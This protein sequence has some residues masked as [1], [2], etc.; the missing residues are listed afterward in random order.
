MGVDYA[1]KTQSVASTGQI[2]G[3]NGNFFTDGVSGNIHANQGNFASYVQ[4]GAGG[5]GLIDAHGNLTIGGFTASGETVAGSLQT[6]T[7]NAQT[8]T[9]VANTLLRHITGASAFTGLILTAGTEA[10]QEVILVNDSANAQTFA[11]SGT[12]NVAEGTSAN[13]PA[14]G[15]LVLVW[16]ANLSLWV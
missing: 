6:L 13:V 5:G 15:K 8:I 7:A 11:A 4:T 12:S 9:L 1:V 3:D 10:G 14:N 2:S 16:S